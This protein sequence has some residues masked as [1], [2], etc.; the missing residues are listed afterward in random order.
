[1]ITGASRLSKSRAFSQNDAGGGLFTP[2]LTEWGLSYWIPSWG[3]K[4][5]SPVRRLFKLV[6][7]VGSF[8]LNNSV[9]TPESQ[10]SKAPSSFQNSLTLHR[11]LK[12][13]CSKDKESRN[14]AEIGGTRWKEVRGMW[15]PLIQT[16][17]IKYS[18]CPR[19]R[20]FGVCIN[21]DCLRSFTKMF[22]SLCKRKVKKQIFKLSSWVGQ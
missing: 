20:N 4:F 1:M 15:S 7:A 8:Q 10:G 16:F 21:P 12:F 14:A 3:L 9:L 19:N 22:L 18:S 5:T 13:H 17:D 11:I 2:Q 6:I